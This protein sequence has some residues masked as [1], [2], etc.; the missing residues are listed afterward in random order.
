MFLSQYLNI[1]K[2]HLMPCINIIILNCEE[3][4]YFDFQKSRYLFIP[5]FKD[6]LMCQFLCP[7][8]YIIIQ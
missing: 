5:S 2:G 3:F 4:L 8:I 6:Y 7:I 1:F